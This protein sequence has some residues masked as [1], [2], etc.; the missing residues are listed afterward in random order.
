MKHE[1]DGF[2]YPH[3]KKS[4][5]IFSNKRENMQHFY[6][7][8]SPLVVNEHLDFECKALPANTSVSDVNKVMT[9]MKSVESHYLKTVLGYK[10]FGFQD[11]FGL[12]KT[13]H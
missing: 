11:V 4:A 13:S 7:D 12:N 10:V 1:T 9:T 3:K 6:P 5:T 2:S 8:L